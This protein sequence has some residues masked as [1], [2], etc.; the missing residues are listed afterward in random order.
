MW[1]WTLHT[2]TWNGTICFTKSIRSST[3]CSSVCSV[4]TKEFNHY[5]MYRK[6]N[7]F[8][9]NTLS[10]TKPYSSQVISAYQ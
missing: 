9:E 5:S 3:G 2:F 4:G 6:C 8:G 7:E 1:K 10:N